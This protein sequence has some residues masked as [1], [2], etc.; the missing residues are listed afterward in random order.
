MIT[1]SIPPVYQFG[2]AKLMNDPLHHDHKAASLYSISDFLMDLID[3][4]IHFLQQRYGTEN[5][6]STDMPALGQRREK[7]SA[8]RGLQYRE[9]TRPEKSTV[10]QNVTGENGKCVSIAGHIQTLIAGN[11]YDNNR[12]L[13]FPMKTFSQITAMIR[14]IRTMTIRTKNLPPISIIC[15]MTKWYFHSGRRYAP[16]LRKKS[17][18]ENNRQSPAAL[19]FVLSWDF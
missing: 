5:D 1:V 4:I 10:R 6:P 15:Y 2:T 3:P 14:A 11:D 9:E 16:F 13:V 18:P 12:F 19:F 7:H 8:C 17:H